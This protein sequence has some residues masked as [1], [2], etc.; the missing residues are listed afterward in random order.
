MCRDIKLENTLLDDSL[1]RPNVKLCDF[2]YSKNEF[3]DSRPKSVS[4]TPDY[5]AP[6]VLLN[7]NYD[8][9]TADIWSC[10]VMLYVMMTGGALSLCMSSA[11][12]RHVCSS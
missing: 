7:D 8:G 6:E 10:G 2:G 4:G 1:P 11:F 9:K 5:I 12:L 3:V